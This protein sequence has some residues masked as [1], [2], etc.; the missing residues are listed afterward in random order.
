[1]IINKRYSLQLTLIYNKNDTYIFSMFIIEI[2]IFNY[3][4]INRKMTYIYK[5]K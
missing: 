4:I 2:I 3:F 1:M 5:M